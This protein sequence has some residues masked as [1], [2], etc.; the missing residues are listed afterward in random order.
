M[1]TRSSCSRGA[2]VGSGGD[3]DTRLALEL[4][5]ALHADVPPDDPVHTFLRAAYRERVQQAVEGLALETPLSSARVAELETLERYDRYKVDR[6][7]QASMILDWSPHV[8]PFSEFGAREKKGGDEL[9]DAQPETLAAAVDARLADLGDAPADALARAVALGAVLPGFLA[10]PRLEPM[11]GAVAELPPDQRIA[12]LEGITLIAGRCEHWPTVSAACQRFEALMSQSD[13]A[14]RTAPA[15]ALARLSSTLRRAGQTPR[16]LEMLGAQYEALAGSDVGLVTARL[17]LATAMAT[18]GEPDH[19]ES[20]TAVGL[21]LLG[22]AT[23]IP[24]QRLN[25]TR[26]LMLALG[27]GSPEQAVA[28]VRAL[29]KGFKTITDSFNTNSHFCLS[30]LAFVES[31]VLGLAR[32]DVLGSER[33]RRFV[34]DDEHCLRQRLFAAPAS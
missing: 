16:V 29:L 33:A 3:E 32:P 12:T 18:L 28:G 15:L 23:L 13:L 25:L 24:A 14:D 21:E 6:L 10:V 11:L 1:A 34:E 31:L 5:D 17:Q 30:V 19:L 8:D 22:S 20:A 27:R 26:Q 9:G 2:S 4:A 7:R